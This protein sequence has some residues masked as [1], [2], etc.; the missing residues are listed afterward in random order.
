MEEIAQ[1]LRK[2]GYLAL[3]SPKGFDMKVIRPLKS[4]IDSQE[5]AHVFGRPE[6]I[7]QEDPVDY[8]VRKMNSII[9]ANVGWGTID[10]LSNEVIVPTKSSHEKFE[11]M[12]RHID[13]CGFRATVHDN[14]RIIHVEVLTNSGM[15]VGRQFSFEV[16]ESVITNPIRFVIDEMSAAEHATNGTQFGSASYLSVI[17]QRVEDKGYSV[18]ITRDHLKIQVSKKLHDGFIV[19]QT[20]DAYELPSLIDDSVRIIIGVMEQLIEDHLEFKG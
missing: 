11:E 8:V 16:L 13:A 15:V 1:K 19:I 12:A 2:L 18:A 4:G 6:L 5:A 9:V 3:V 14:Q 17:A 10:I 7:D 20:F